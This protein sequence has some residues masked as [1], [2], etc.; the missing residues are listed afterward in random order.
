MQ[1]K[2]KYLPQSQ[3]ELEVSLSDEEMKPFWK[4]ARNEVLENVNLNGFRK[5][6]IPDELIKNTDLEEKIFDEAANQA[7]KQSIKK[8]TEELNLEL[9]GTPEI[10]ITKIA[11]D[12]EFVYILKSAILPHPEIKNYKEISGEIFKKKNKLEVS[13]KEVEEALKWLQKSRSSFNKVDRIIKKGDFVELQIKAFVDD[14]KIKDFPEKDQ[15]IIGEGG[16]PKDFEKQIEGMKEGGEK[17]F[18]IKLPEDF[19]N[20][21]IKGKE[22]KFQVKVLSVSEIKLPE[23]ND[24]WA[25]S[26]G[27]F[28]NIKD[29]TDS[30][31]E[32]MIEEKQIKER[33][34]LRLLLLNKLIEENEFELPEILVKSE[35]ENQMHSLEHFLQDQNLSFDDYLKKIKKTTKDLEDEVRKEAEK[36]L[37]GFIILRTIASLENIVPNDNEIEKAMN[38]ILN[39][40]VQ[41]GEDINQID[42]ESLKEYIKERLTSEKV[43][44]YLENLVKDSE[45]NNNN[46]NKKEI[47]KN[48]K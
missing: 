37:K 18:K 43:F 20:E 12:N 21:E 44:Q 47:P 31:K 29:L 14:K 19:F 48:K 45:E 4:T 13:E 5:S 22:A 39:Q 26:L 11:P 32:G 15:F 2:I 9:I 38:D 40:Q 34:R 36:T 42:K 8:I 23:L 7:F 30:I 27:N 24:D 41:R 46:E 35:T 10:N 25:K 1:H 28:Q 16:Y 3:I 17:E 6:A 33:D